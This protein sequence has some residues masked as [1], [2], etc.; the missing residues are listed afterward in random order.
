MMEAAAAWRAFVHDLKVETADGPMFAGIL[1]YDTHGD[2]SYE[3]G[4]FC[5][6]VT[7]EAKRALH[8]AFADVQMRTHRLNLDNHAFHVVDN[9]YGNI[10][11][12]GRHRKMGL[13]S[14]RFPMG[15]VVAVFQWPH[16][17]QTT[18]PIMAKFGRKLCA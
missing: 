9:V 1:V 13:L 12:V 18:A 3:E 4:W 15:T 17:L 14:Q 5:N 10:C 2:V 16:T 6:H 7:A 8:P 11:A